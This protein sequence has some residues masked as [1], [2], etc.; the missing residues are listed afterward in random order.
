VDRIADEIP[1]SAPEIV[2][3]FL[4]VTRRYDGPI[5]VTAQVP[6]GEK[7]GRSQTFSVLGWH[8]NHLSTNL[9]SLHGL[10]PI[11][12]DEVVR[13]KFEAWPEG[14]CITRKIVSS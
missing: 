4:A 11:H 8:A 13:S 9:T 14:N 10:K 1:N 6:S 2:S 7:L 12:N 3:Q 5:G